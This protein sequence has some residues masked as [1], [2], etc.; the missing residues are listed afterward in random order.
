MLGSGKPNLPAQKQVTNAVKAALDSVDGSEKKAVPGTNADSPETASIYA[1]TNIR[2]LV[3]ATIQQWVETDDLE[4]DESLPDR[5]LMMLVGIADANQDGELD[6]DES[7]V[8]DM[9]LETAWD[10]LLGK[11]VTDDDCSLL[12]NDWDADAAIRISDVVAAALPD[13]DDL[14]SDDIDEFAFGDDEQGAVFDSAGTKE[15]GTED[16]ASTENAALDAVY[17]KTLVIRHGKKVRINKR[18][19]GK[20]RLSAKQKIGIR[21]AQLKS[22]SARA[23]MRRMKSRTIG[24][25]M[26]M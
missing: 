21:K 16:D 15:P 24:N 13:G 6:D 22:H 11:G 26:G 1:D 4:D 17:K 10:Y 5:L 23:I 18:V 14:A 25:R 7:A 3:A 12:L 9:A 19:S 20:V 2:L 8:L